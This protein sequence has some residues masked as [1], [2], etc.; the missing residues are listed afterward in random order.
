MI[1]KVVPL[2]RPGRTFVV[3]EAA[4]LANSFGVRR[5]TTPDSF[6]VSF[7]ARQGLPLQMAGQ[8]TRFIVALGCLLLS[9][10]GVRGEELPR[11]GFLGLNIDPSKPGPVPK[12]YLISSVA[13]GSLAAALEIRVGD[14]LVYIEKHLPASRAD[15]AEIAKGLRAGQRVTIDISRSGQ[16]RLL[17]G[18]L[19]EM[20]A[21]T[22]PNADVL[23]E[24]VATPKGEKLRVIVTRPK[25]A[26]GKLPVI[27]VAGWLSCDSVEAPNDT[28]DATS[29]VFQALAQLPGFCT[30]RMDKQGVGDS[31]GVCA[32]TDFESELAGYRA[33]F[34]SLGQHDFIDADQVYLLGISN[35][36]GFAPLVPETVAEQATV[37]G[38]VSVGGWVKTWVEHMLEI[39]RRRFTLSGKAPGDVND[40]MKSA[41]ALYPEWL[42]KG[43]PVDEIVR[44]RPSLAEI[45]PEGPDRTHL[46]GRPLAFY[47]QLQ[48]LN[49]AAAWSRVTVPTLLLRGQYDWI[50][51]RED[52]EMMAG[53]V[54]ASRPGA[55]RFM[56]LPA[57]G[58][59]FQHYTS[60]EDAFRGKETSFDPATA[61]VLVDWFK[62]VGQGGGS[63]S[64]EK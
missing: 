40:R 11:R 24:S 43:R 25:G 32:E 2:V 9:L 31:E 14:D 13:P 10:A 36:G 58:H 33:A 57:T 56:E 16:S 8:G 52:P 28:T 22:Y 12:T 30:V 39:E 63:S 55:A 50:M 53:F 47:Q 18:I 38:Y 20:P 23:Y 49:L 60:M 5:R 35:G 59:T 62:Q 64:G 46:Y 19:P 45:W 17:T 26:T 42:V 61:R 4:S 41:A 29:S 3:G 44:E 27:F 48:K 15:L 1:S 37:R 7:P 21:E 34:R 51:S 54:N 6:G